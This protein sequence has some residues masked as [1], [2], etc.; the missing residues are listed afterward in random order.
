MSGRPG[1]GTITK[2][3]DS[4]VQCPPSLAYWLPADLGSREEI[5]AFGRPQRA[6]REPDSRGRVSP[7][8]GFIPWCRANMNAGARPAVPEKGGSVLRDQHRDLE[9]CPDDVGTSGPPF[10]EAVIGA[11]GFGSGSGNVGIA[12]NVR[13]FFVSPCPCPLRSPG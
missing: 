13:H 1:T 2:P 11:V 8:A 9:R 4:A 7:H 3:R 6:T 10:Q 12:V 5:S